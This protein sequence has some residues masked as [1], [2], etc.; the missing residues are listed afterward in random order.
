MPYMLPWEVTA[1]RRGMRKGRKEGKDAGI[2]EGKDAGIK[3]GKEAGIKETAKKMAEIGIDIDKIM[4]ATGLKREVI[5]KLAAV[6][7]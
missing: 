3:E 5:E 7:H 6:S 1:E 2:K 4:K